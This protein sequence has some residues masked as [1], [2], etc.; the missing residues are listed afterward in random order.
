M[1]SVKLGCTSHFNSLPFLSFS[2]YCLA[3]SYLTLN[4]LEISR[5][6]LLLF[7]YIKVMGRKICYGTMTFVQCARRLTQETSVGKYSAII[8]VQL[9]LR[10]VPQL[11]NF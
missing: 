5:H 6:L 9:V 7:D 2:K 4:N 10:N 8:R 11:Q 1:F 3:E